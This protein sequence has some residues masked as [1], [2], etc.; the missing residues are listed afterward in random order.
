[1][2]VHLEGIFADPGTDNVRTGCC[3]HDMPTMDHPSRIRRGWARVLTG[4]QR[5]FRTKQP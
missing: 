5:V 2:T 1:M 3:G 4:M